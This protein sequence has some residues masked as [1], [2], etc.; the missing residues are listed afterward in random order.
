MG[1]LVPVVA[2]YSSF[3]QR[4]VDQILHDVC[5]QK[6]HVIFAVD[7]AGLVGADGETHQGCFDLS[8][9]SMMPNM[10]VLAPKNDRELEEM[11][12]FAV[13]LTD[14]LQ[15]AIREAVRIRGFRNTRHLWNMAEV[16]LSAKE[17]K[18]LCWEW[19]V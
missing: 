19:E 5:M 9:L 15:S 14:R 4:A 3:L 11:L 13:A 17:K 18:S 7:R 8:Y 1:G 12:A 10:T 2:I 16:R 6:L